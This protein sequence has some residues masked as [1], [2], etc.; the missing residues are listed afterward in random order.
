MAKNCGPSLSLTK[1]T[2]GIDSAKAELDNLIGTGVN[3]LADSAV[4]LKDKISGLTDGIGADLDSMAPEI[5]QPKFKLQ[6][7]M[8]NLLNNADNPGG[9]IK[10]MDEIREQFGS[11]VDVDKMFSDFG[12]DADELN[13]LNKDYKDKLKLGTE[14][15][16]QKNK[17]TKFLDGKTQELIA[18]AT[19]DLSAIGNLIGGAADKI[20]GGND[21][22]DLKDKV[23]TN[24]PNV[25]MDADGNIITKG[26]ESKAATEDAEAE[27][28][29]AERKSDLLPSIKDQGKELANQIMNL[30]ELDA[31]PF[32]FGFAI[33]VEEIEKEGVNSDEYQADSD[34]LREYQITLRTDRDAY[35]K[36]RNEGGEIDLDREYYHNSLNK[37]IELYGIHI[38]IKYNT[39]EN[40]QDISVD[41]RGDSF[42]LPGV[43]KKTPYALPGSV[44]ESFFNNAPKNSSN[45]HKPLGD[46]LK[47]LEFIEIQSE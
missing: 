17:G 8:T 7:Q 2:D 42:N 29:T 16:T 5:P 38:A 4:A 43:E 10:Q 25:E 22:E 39:T 11:T 3:G 41:I 46:K 35:N 14:L 47:S 26:T 18:L 27:S 13:A 19:G 21:I 37:L 32:T 20:F 40:K 6:D 12:L 33:S 24:I 44:F 45:R 34:S 23:C 28:E 1:L 36:S 15:S 31:E 9:L 30:D